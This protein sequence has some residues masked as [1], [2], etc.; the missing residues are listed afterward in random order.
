[1]IE[2]LIEQ[3]IERGLVTREE[4]EEKVAKLRAEQPPVLGDLESLKKRQDETENV[5]LALLLGGM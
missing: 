4:I 3:Y 5:L 1:M 2:Q